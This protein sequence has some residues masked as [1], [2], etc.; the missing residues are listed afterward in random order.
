MEAFLSS[1]SSLPFFPGA[2]L[3]TVGSEGMNSHSPVLLPDR[4]T[5]GN[6][7]SVQLFPEYHPSG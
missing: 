6:L 4:M 1:C 5:S 2:T 3:I 7:A